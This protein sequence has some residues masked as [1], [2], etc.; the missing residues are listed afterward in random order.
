MSNP[1]V[2][3]IIPCYNAEKWVSRGLES[4][5]NQAFDDI[6][7]IAI[8]DGS[9]DNTEIVLK[10]FSEQDERIRI[11]CQ[12]NRGVSAARNIGLEVA[13][14]EW[15]MFFDIDDSIMERSLS[16]LTDI[17]AQQ[18]EIDFVMAGY[19]I[20]R[21]G[22]QSPVPRFR[23]TQYS[24]IDFC[25]EL[26]SPTDYPYQG[27]ICSKLYRRSIIE[28]HNI[29][30]NE[31]IKYNEDRLFTFTYLSHIKRGIYT[32][33]PVYN[34]IQ[35]GDNAMSA[36]NGPNFWR[37]E[38]DLDA[39]LEMNRIAAAF[40]SREITQ[41]VRLGTISSYN[42]NRR[43]NKQYGNNNPETNRRLKKKL[44]S[45]V[46][47]LFMFQSFC[48]NEYYKIKSR[49]YSLAVKIGVK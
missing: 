29:R 19:I 15:I 16:I 48:R 32:T 40:K 11:I 39:F 3:I 23:N 27:Y 45:A 1:L 36:I 25:K 46:P 49:L 43:L 14:G 22:V 30:F 20:T 41:L 7:I 6:E 17:I 31:A 12:N 26:F 18:E 44:F 37:F 9:T 21:A 34:Y 13:N 24:N 33:E 35:H 2:S 8:N 5:L 38:T 4:L 28:K 47:R 10:N 42:W